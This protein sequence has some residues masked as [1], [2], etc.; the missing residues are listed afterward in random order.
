MTV[1]ER[2]GTGMKNWYELDVGVDHA[3]SLD[4]KDYFLSQ[5]ERPDVTQIW[6]PG[7]AG[8]WR[9]DDATLFEPTWV[10]QVK[11]RTGLSINGALIFYRSGGYQHPGAHID[12]EP[13]YVQ[14]EKRLVPVSAAY[15]WVLD[16]ADSEMVWYEPWWDAEDYEQCLAAAQSQTKFDAQKQGDLEYAEIELDRLDEM[17]R[18]PI[19]TQRLTMVRT[20]VPHNVHM[21][22]TD[23]WCVSARTFE[24]TPDL[25]SAARNNLEA[26]I[27]I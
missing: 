23:R 4:V 21:G 3:L 24:T 10:E 16:S 1:S 15:N 26:A 12:I 25:W 8:V 18:H 22:P 27:L 19:S 17:E 9:S 2:N 13:R 6:V 5:P 20:N 7:V 14:D 11:K